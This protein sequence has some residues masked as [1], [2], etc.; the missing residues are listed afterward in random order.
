MTDTEFE[1]FHEQYRTS[2]TDPNNTLRQDQILNEL[3]RESYA[4]YE[5]GDPSA[6]RIVDRTEALAECHIDYRNVNRHGQWPAGANDDELLLFD[7]DDHP[8]WKIHVGNRLTVPVDMEAEYWERGLND[9]GD[10]TTTET[11][12]QFIE[13]RDRYATVEARD[14]FKSP[15][16]PRPTRAWRI[17][18]NPEVALCDG[19]GTDVDNDP[20]PADNP[21]FW[22]ELFQKYVLDE[23]VPMHLL[24]TRLRLA[25]RNPPT[26][27]RAITDQGNST[28]TPSMILYSGKS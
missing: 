26:G 2:W 8:T 12:D 27:I 22:N 23:R 24:R 9:V 4:R 16:N 7:G 11:R 20:H 25:H 14:G 21:G 17:V 18:Q 5:I 6:A 1:G 28:L 13:R 3:I 19:F 10:G 15:F